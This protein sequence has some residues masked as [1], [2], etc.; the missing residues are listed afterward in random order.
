MER[1]E[2]LL[3]MVGKT[4][5]VRGGGGWQRTLVLSQI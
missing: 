2:A 3:G 5:V 1:L 4:V